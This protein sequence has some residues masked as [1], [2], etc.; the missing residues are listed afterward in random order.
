ML[1][2]LGYTVGE[3]LLVGCEID[4]PKCFALTLQR[5]R[6]YFDANLPAHFDAADLVL[7]EIVGRNL[8]K[9]L[10]DM[11]SEA[12]LPVDLHPHIPGLEW[13]SNGHGDFALGHTLVEIKCTAKR[14]SSSDYRQV[15]IYWLLSY[16]ADIEGRGKEWRDFVLVNPR[17]GEKVSMHFD[18]FL[19]IISNGRSKVDI[20]QLFQSLVGSRLTR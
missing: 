17:R 11:S 18:A 7:A 1:F 20:L 12:N 4:W 8:S 2:E 5:Q 13:I 19:S 9:A 16:A 6:V 14:F 10:Q 15:A 3:H